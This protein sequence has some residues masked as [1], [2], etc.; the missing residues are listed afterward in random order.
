MHL[1]GSG[2]TKTLTSRVAYLLSHHKYQPW[3]IIV[4]TFTVKAAKEMK[5]RIGALLG[6]GLESKLILGTFHSI[7][8]RYLVGIKFLV[9][10]TRDC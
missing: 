3:N 7:A 4:A 8:R 10:Q 6:D 9:N 2:K 1:A 5:E